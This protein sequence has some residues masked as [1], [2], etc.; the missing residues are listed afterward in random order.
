VDDLTLL[1]S[2]FLHI[3]IDLMGSHPTSA[4]YTYYLT[5]VDRFT[6]WP[7]VIPIPDNTNDIAGRALLACWISCFGFPQTLTT[8]H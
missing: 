3:H 5:V 1:A 6:C 7:E 2:H 8:D 4:G